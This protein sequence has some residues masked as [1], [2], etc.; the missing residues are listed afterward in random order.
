MKINFYGAAGEV[1]GSC[2]L[3]QS[4]NTRVLVD[5]GAFQ[6]GRRERMRNNKKFPFNPKKIDAVVLTHAHYDHCGRIPKLIT[7]GFKGP[8][9]TTLAT[10]HLMR[11]V[12]EDSLK[13]MEYD[14]KDHGILPYFTESHLKQ[15]LSQVETLDYNQKVNFKGGGSLTLKDAGHILGSASVKLNIGG[16]VVVFSGDLGN[17]GAPIV[18]DT[19][20]PK[21]ADVVVMESTYA[22]REHEPHDKRVSKL[23]QALVNTYEQKGVLLIP[24]FAIER[25]QE[26][27]WELHKLS[28]KH[29]LPD[30]KFFLDSPMAIKVTKDFKHHPEVYDKQAL[31]AYNMHHDFLSFPNLVLTPSVDESKAINREPAPKVIIAG[32]GM[33]DGGRIL[34]HLKR[35]ISHNNTTILVVG[36]Q[37]KNTLGRKI[38]SGEKSIK[39]GR[40]FIPVH[41]KLIKADSYSAHADYRQLV[42]WLKSIK[43]LPKAVFLNHGEKGTSKE[44]AEYLK[45]KLDLNTIVSKY[46]RTYNIKTRKSRLFSASSKKS[47]QVL[48]Q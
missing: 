33:M 13:I 2:T 31:E 28:D 17:P 25:T 6:G 35:Y 3:V 7:Y 11:I 19:D 4:G 20:M 1:T 40:R 27:L 18:K 10:K 15:A 34:H 24:A 47:D 46:K 23:E 38:L 9:F 43:T 32:S 37:A 48:K 16:R 22:M 5:C 26:I 29:K 12:L 21:E 39:I 14:Y 41:A 44:F 30:M 45:A 8:I 42:E 36:Y